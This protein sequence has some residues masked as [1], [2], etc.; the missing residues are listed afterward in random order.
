MDDMARSAGGKLGEFAIPATSEKT[1][2]EVVKGIITNAQEM[3][4]SEV[5]LARAEV[6]EEINKSLAAAK[7]LA[8][9]AVAGLF[10]LAFVLL[11]VSR[12]LALAMPSWV[13][14]LVVGVVLGAVAAVLLMN[15]RKDL[16]VPTPDKTIENVK[17]N[18][19]WMKNQTKS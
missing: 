9:A 2:G 17:E 12:L 10:A 3:V 8:V 5:R 11:A 4:R 15:S 6:R 1:T 18:V 14:S 16:R 13:A 7:K 19:E